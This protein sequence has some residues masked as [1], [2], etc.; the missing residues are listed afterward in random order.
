MLLLWI[1]SSDLPAAYIN[2]EAG[3]VSNVAPLIP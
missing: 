1:W 2:N 3:P